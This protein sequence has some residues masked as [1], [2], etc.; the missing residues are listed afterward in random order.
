MP[1]DHTHQHIST[2]IMREDNVHTPIS[3]SGD[4]QIVSLLG[5]FHIAWDTADWENI[6]SF[7]LTELSTGNVII[8][9]WLEITEGWDGAAPT[10]YIGIGVG[11]TTL[12]YVGPDAGSDYLPLT[13]YVDVETTP[14]PP[15]G[16]VREATISEVP[17][18]FRVTGARGGLVAF[19]D[20]FAINTSGQ[21]DVYALI[22]TPS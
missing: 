21:A 1:I 17:H 10:D 15:M 5:P 11:G 16:I 6:N 3:S 9:A 7:L 8:R 19:T 4:I 22:A 14:T 12:D 18:V 2:D 13:Q 20:G